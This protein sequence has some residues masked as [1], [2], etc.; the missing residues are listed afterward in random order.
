MTGSSPGSKPDA[1]LCSRNEIQG[2][3]T[4]A[5]RGAGLPWGL[6][7]EAGWAACWLEMRGIAGAEALAANLEALADGDWRH[8]MPDPS[9][10]EWRAPTGIT[11]GLL[12]GV[13]MADRAGL[14]LSQPGNTLDLRNVRWPVLMA[15]FLADAVCPQSCTMVLHSASGEPTVELHRHAV[16]ADIADLATEARIG[17]LQLVLREGLM[18]GPAAP[19]L[20]GSLPINDDAYARLEQW[21]HKTY[22]PESAESQ[23]R[24]AGGADLIETD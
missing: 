6:A 21:A 17:R 24:G 22:V 1:V 10:N 4:K 20:D 3:A 7:E 14:D 2:L 9:G 19:I 13:T 12:A 23:A 5:A 18:T 11:D 15:P 8:D 16:S